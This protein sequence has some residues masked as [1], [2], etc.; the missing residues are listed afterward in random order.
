MPTSSRALVYR[1]RSP[2]LAGT[3]FAIICLLVFQAGFACSRLTLRR[4]GN[5]LPR[6]GAGSQARIVP[7]E[8]VNAWPTIVDVRAE[9]VAML[10]VAGLNP[11]PVFAG[12]NLSNLQH[13]VAWISS[14]TRPG[15][16][17]SVAIAGDKD[18]YFHLLKDVVAGDS[19]ELF[20]AA[21]VM[22]YMVDGIAI[23]PRDEPGALQDRG[24]SSILLVTGY[25]FDF[26]GDPPMWLIVHGML[27][28]PDL[29]GV[30]ALAANWSRTRIGGGRIRL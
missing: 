3:R 15:E 22:S 29:L 25:P 28:S 14:T 12:V 24:S 20:T 6:E 16:L 21:N 18:T 17:G 19:I 5:A 7:I 8:P 27:V 30:R 2:L 1:K 11:I 4:L 23:V 9:T 13:G 26:A 10:R